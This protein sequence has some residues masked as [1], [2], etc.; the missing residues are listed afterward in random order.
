M[1]KQTTNKRM[2]NCGEGHKGTHT[3]WKDRDRRIAVAGGGGGIR[4][5]H[6]F[7]IF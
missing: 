2:I 6:R 1:N 3:R 5:G 7:E 4:E